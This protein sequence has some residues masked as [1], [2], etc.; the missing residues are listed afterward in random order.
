MKKYCAIC[1]KVVENEDAPI[2]THGGSGLPR[3]L[4]SGCERDIDTAT[5]GREY[6]EIDAAM[7]R[8]SAN[9]VGANVE[10]TAVFMALDD[11]LSSAKDRA[12]QIKAGEYDF[13]LDEE[14]AEMLEELPED[15]LESEEDKRLDEE[16]EVKYKKLDKILNWVWIAALVGAAGFCVWWV[17]RFTF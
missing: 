10:D 6:S 13:S 12:L 4:C 7:D 5:L 11:I 9:L 15:M 17:I 2:L 3:Y 16:E 8:I 1:G 14:E